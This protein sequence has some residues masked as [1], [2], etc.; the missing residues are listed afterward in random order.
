MVNIARSF[1]FL[2]ATTEKDGRC[3]D[4]TVGEG[5]SRCIIRQNFN[6]NGT[7]KTVTFWLDLCH[8]ISIAPFA[9]RILSRLLRHNVRV[10]RSTTE[11]TEFFTDCGFL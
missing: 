3:S 9:I 5:T 6:Q 11:K 10:F 1:S 2:Q 8:I 4:S 7:H